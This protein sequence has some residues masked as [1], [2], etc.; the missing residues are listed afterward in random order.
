MGTLAITNIGTLVSGDLGKS[1]L[2]ADTVMVKDG[3]ISQIGQAKEFDLSQVDKIVD[4]QGSTLTP[5]FIDSHVHIV[6]AEWTPRQNAI[7]YIESYLHGGV[8]TLISSGEAHLPG[9]PLDRA[10][11]KAL[12]ILAHKA[13]LN[14][15]PSGVKVIAGRV[16]LEPGLLEED[17]AEMAAEGVWLAKVGLGRIGRP[18]ES[19]LMT[20]WAHKHGM[21]V[22]MHTGGASIPGT[23]PI[24]LDDLIQT[25]PD[26]CAHANGGP[27]GL[28][29]KDLRTL[30]TETEL[31]LEMVQAGNAKR[32]GEAIR[33]AEE[34]GALPRIVVGTDTPTGTGIISL[35]ILKTLAEIC[36]LCNTPPEKAIALATGNT[37]RVYG[38]N[39]G[40]IEE[41]READFVIMDAPLGS[42]G[43]DAMEALQEGDIPGISAV[44]I[45]G[46]VLIRKSRNTP[47][48]TRMAIVRDRIERR[49]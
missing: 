37:A 16:V 42:V 46:E 41:G 24:G 26:V 45:D 28:P 44:I 34:I 49:G 2:R 10:G 20:D 32:R 25:Q 21:K 30:V 7:G 23:K 36:G 17:F 31:V 15:R 11:V 13:F 8:T 3:L 6:F 40:M 1:L 38:L 4:A 39:R 14:Y 48:A 5:G 43:R 18:P 27:T 22:L 33:L 29:Q 19:V 12:A 47:P 9:R 35:G